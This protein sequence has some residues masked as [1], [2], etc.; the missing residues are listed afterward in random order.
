M[1][2]FDIL[3]G[4]LAAA[5][6]AL[7]ARNMLQSPSIRVPT[8]ARGG[9]SRVYLR[10]RPVRPLVYVAGLPR[11]RP[12]PALGARIAALIRQ[13][14]LD[15]T[16]A[17]TLLKASKPD[18][19]KRLE[20]DIEKARLAYEATGNPRYR[21]RLASLRR[22]YMDIARST[23]PYAGATVLIIWAEPGRESEARALKTLLEAETGLELKPHRGSVL[24]A[25]LRS[26]SLLGSGPAALPVPWVESAGESSIAIGVDPDYGALVALEWPRDFETHV[27][28]I[29]PTG[30]GKTVL[31]LGLAMQLS[32]PTLRERPGLVVIDPKGD[33]APRVA[34]LVPG[35]EYWDDPVSLAREACERRSTYILGP[36][37]AERGAELVRAM[38]ECYTRGEARGRTVLLVDEAWRYLGE[39]AE[40]MEA[41]VR[42]GRS[43]GLHIVYSTQ[44]FDDIS[45]TIAENTG[46]LIVFGGT[47]ESYQR[48]ASALGLPGEELAV[49][50]VGTAI[51]RIRGRTVRVRVFNFESYAE[52]PGAQQ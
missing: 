28:I 5:S 25:L 41:T 35:A 20:R 21:E 49:L 31:L 1:G 13:S 26:D 27:G 9:D 30:K 46:V 4:A 44:S 3:L 29:G 11:G 24:Q 14:G 37:P 22:L 42:Q 8:R 32:L 50:P 48:K 39:A 36:G 7:M 15:A 51:A 47:A 23:R 12:D 38:L 6:L 18:L 19:M 33:L 2:P 34:R 17:F 40:Y 45:E 16:L 52:G 10:G 43:L